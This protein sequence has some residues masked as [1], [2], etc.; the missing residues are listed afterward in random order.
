MKTEI[1]RLGY[2]EEWLQFGIISEKFALS[3]HTEFLN[4]ED[5]NEDHYRWGA[6]VLYMN[7]KE[8]LTDDEIKNIFLLKDSGLDKCELHS[9]R[10]HWLISSGKLNDFQYDSL[11]RYP[12]VLEPPLQKVFLRHK[13]LREINKEGLSETIFYKVMETNDSFIH[14]RILSREDLNRGHVEWLSKYGLNKRVR[15]IASELLKTRR[16]RISK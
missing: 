6:F 10:I 11:V 14:E 8:I 9:N 1:A 7:S 5:K 2:T 12:E 15:N 4:S 16:F 3:Q 13:L